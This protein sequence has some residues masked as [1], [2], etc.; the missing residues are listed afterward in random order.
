M[1]TAASYETAAH[2]EII[3]IRYRVEDTYMKREMAEE[4]RS[5]F[6]QF[7]NNPRQLVPGFG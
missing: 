1:R 3:K 2:G 7:I 6:Q 4:A 5:L